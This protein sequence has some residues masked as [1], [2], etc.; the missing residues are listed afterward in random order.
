MKPSRFPR[1]VVLLLPLALLTV[2]RAPATDNE[3][4][5]KTLRGI[6][7]IN[8]LV[9]PLGSDAKD[10]GLS[11]Q[12]IQTDVELKLRMAGITVVTEVESLKAPG[13]PVLYVF[14]QTKLSG[15]LYAF[16]I[17]VSLEQGVLLARD[18]SVFIL[19]STWSASSIGAVGKSNLSQVRGSV[20]DAADQ[21]LNAY[22]SVNPRK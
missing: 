14:V 11:E 19:T 3:V 17:T 8:V 6:S 9:E 2:C 16:S 4:T 21:F 18:T 7:R 5:R 15:G 22:L 12:S 13:M 10:D 20:G 1:S